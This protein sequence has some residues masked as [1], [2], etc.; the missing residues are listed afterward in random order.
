MYGPPLLKSCS[1]E[2]FEYFFFVN[3]WKNRNS[4]P[5]F[6]A[7]FCAVQLRDISKKHFFLRYH[8]LLWAL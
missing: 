7:D 4:L 6:S 2:L 1:V 8:R 5:D 3:L